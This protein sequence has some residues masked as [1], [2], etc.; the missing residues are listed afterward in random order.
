MR[1]S[2]PPVYWPATLGLSLSWALACTTR[3]MPVHSPTDASP[4]TSFVAAAEEDCLLVST[5]GMGW[6]ESSPL[7]SPQ[8]V[9]AAVDGSCQAPF[10]WDASAWSGT[11]AV[12]PTRWQSTLATTVALDPASAR[13]VT[14]TPV[15]PMRPSRDPCEP[16]LLVDGTITLALPEGAVVNQRRFTM[17]A[18]VLKKPNHL[19]VTLNEPELASWVSLHKLDQNLVFAAS[20]DVSAPALAC[21]GQILLGY[22][23]G[24]ATGYSAVGRFAT[25]S[26]TPCAFGWEA[27]DVDQPWPDVPLAATIR[28]VFDG[29]AIPGRWNDGKATTLSLATSLPTTSVCAQFPAIGDPDVAMP[30]D[31]RV[32]TADARVQ[33]LA[34]TGRMFVQTNRSGADGGVRRLQLWLDTDSVCAS[35]TDTLPYP[36]ADCATVRQV[37]AHLYLD[38]SPAPALAGCGGGSLALVVSRRASGLDQTDRLYLSPRWQ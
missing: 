33:G 12:D 4:G 31:V 35:E 28:A 2:H 21:A 7:G 17:A 23:R 38:C 19:T 37:S 5:T 9:F 10:T 16:L 3:P 8:A 20:I 36:G 13:W 30:A 26:N 11:L 22:R 32:S 29:V 15:Q 34:G 25:W 14:R 18:S 6:S 1:T 24:Q 27:V